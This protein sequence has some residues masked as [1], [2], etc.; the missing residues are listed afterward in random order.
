ML[1]EA[2]EEAEELG[3]EGALPTQFVCAKYSTCER[4]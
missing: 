3:A 4:D 2:E 1:E